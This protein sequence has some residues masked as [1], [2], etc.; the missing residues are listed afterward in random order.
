MQ[1]EERNSVI[2]RGK[3][4][5]NQGQ[6]VLNFVVPKNI[7][8]QTGQGKITAYADDAPSGNTSVMD[9]HGAFVTFEI[10]G[11]QRPSVIDDLPPDIQLFMDD[12]TFTNGSFTGTNTLLLAQLRD[13]HGVSISSSGLGQTITA[14]LSYE[15][16][17]ESRTFELN[18]FYETGVDDFQSGWIRYPLEDLQEGSY[19]LTLRAWDTYNNEGTAELSFRVGEEGELWISEFYNYPNPF[20]EET[21]FVLDHNQPGSA[22]DISVQIYNSQGELVHRMQ[23]TQ[24]EATTRLEE[25]YW[26]GRTAAGEQ[27]PSGVYY[28]IVELQSSNSD[29][30][31]QKTHQLIIAH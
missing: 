29:I 20:S 10:G 9:A 19:R 6:F 28:A 11:S 22:L 21:Q 31:Q 17:G 3:A 18:S 23:T 14:E 12:T 16:T 24:S 15:E 5:V 1:F 8:Y 7:V 4:R 13:E 27:L 26:D 25:L 30:I 2:H